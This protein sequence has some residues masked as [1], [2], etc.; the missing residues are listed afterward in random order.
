MGPLSQGRGMSE[1][2]N[3][4][5]ILGDT[6]WSSSSHAQSMSTHFMIKCVKRRQIKKPPCSIFL[7][8]NFPGSTG[9]GT[10]QLSDRQSCHLLSCMLGEAL[11]RVSLILPGWSKSSPFSQVL[12]LSLTNLA[13]AAFYGLAANQLGAR[14]QIRYCSSGGRT[15]LKYVQSQERKF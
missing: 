7:P 4:V 10:P 13:F 11:G 3:S 8:R 1:R 14:V 6:S 5:M 9:E 2:I 12:K 15:T